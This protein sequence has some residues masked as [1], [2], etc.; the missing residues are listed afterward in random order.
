MNLV[1]RLTRPDGD[2]VLERSRVVLNRK[3]II[4][5]E[6]VEHG[7]ATAANPSESQVCVF[8]NADQI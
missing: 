7:F 8:A 6:S 2:T 4:R 5:V 1:L 3:G